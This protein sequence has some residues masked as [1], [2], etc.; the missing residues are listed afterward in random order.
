MNDNRTSAQI[1]NNIDKLENELKEVLHDYGI[2]EDEI[3]QLQLEKNK[4]SVKI[5]ELQNVADKAKHTKR[6]IEVTLRIERSA[7]WNAKHAGL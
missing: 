1:S 6:E 3:N 7:F 2:V 5:K 4:L